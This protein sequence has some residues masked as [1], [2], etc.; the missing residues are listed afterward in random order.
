MIHWPRDAQSDYVLV[1]LK[2]VCFV[3][4]SV[5]SPP[6]EFSHPIAPD[7]KECVDNLLT[8]LPLEQQTSNMYYT[9][10]LLYALFCHQHAEGGDRQNFSDPVAR[11]IV[12]L[13]IHPGGR[14]READRITPVLARI[15]WGIR[16]VNF[17]EVVNCTQDNSGH[18]DLYECVFHTPLEHFV[19]WFHPESQR[20]SGCTHRRGS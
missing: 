8:S 5:K 19:Y 14:W 15:S 16:I 6:P 9:H 13:G 18:E 11:A 4:R 20:G 3:I 10:L 2:V 7:V 17:V 12:L 1:I